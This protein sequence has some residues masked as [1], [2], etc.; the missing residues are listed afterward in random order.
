M[1]WAVF[2]STV[3]VF[4]AGSRAAEGPTGLVLWCVAVM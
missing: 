2:A 1:P 4:T 3:T